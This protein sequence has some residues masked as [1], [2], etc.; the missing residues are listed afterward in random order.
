MAR[1]AAVGWTLPD[2]QPGDDGPALWAR[3][4]EAAFNGVLPRRAGNEPQLAFW[5]L[6]ARGCPD[7]S[8]VDDGQQPVSRWPAD[9]LPVAAEILETLGLQ[10]PDWRRVLAASGDGEVWFF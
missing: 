1:L 7:L 5:L 4:S 3:L 6:L 9:E 10:P 8:L 2:S